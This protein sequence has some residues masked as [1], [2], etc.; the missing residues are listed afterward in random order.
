VASAS[1]GICFFEKNFL[2]FSGV[3]Q[4]LKLARFLSM[5]PEVPQP[6]GLVP[7]LDGPDPVPNP[8]RNAEDEVPAAEPESVAVV[9]AAVGTYLIMCLSSFAYLA[10]I[11]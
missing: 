1:A 2:T 7:G 9:A 11:S 5:F 8:N 6:P 4:K 10:W 3:G